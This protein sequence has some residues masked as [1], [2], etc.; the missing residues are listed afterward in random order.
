MTVYVKQEKSKEEKIDFTLSLSILLMMLL[1][2]F[3]E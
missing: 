1:R 2:D 3:S